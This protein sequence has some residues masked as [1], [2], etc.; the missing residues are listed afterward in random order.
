M[1]D[2][3]SEKMLRALG[4]RA[5]EYAAKSTKLSNMLEEA[6]T[7][8]QKMPSKLEAKVGDLSF[9]RS[10]D[11]WRLWFGPDEYGDW[12][13]ESPVSVKAKAAILLPA[14]VNQI[15]GDMSE[16][17]DEVDAGLIALNSLPFVSSEDDQ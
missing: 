17:L 3:Q 15:L 16:R 1:P 13:T 5:K 8:L 7:F 2:S 12:V 11:G 6:E 4:E 9:V 14:L 10:Q